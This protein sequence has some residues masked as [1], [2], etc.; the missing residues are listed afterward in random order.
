MDDFKTKNR[1][2]PEIM[3]I[4]FNLTEAA[5]H[6]GGSNWLERNGVNLVRY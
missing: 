3:K 6:L 4:I 2:K 1:F 5:Y